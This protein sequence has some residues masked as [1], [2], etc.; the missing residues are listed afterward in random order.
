MA[1]TS[2]PVSQWIL[3]AGFF[4][5]AST[6]GLQWIGG[7][8]VSPRA[9]AELSAEVH[10]LE[11]APADERAAVAEHLTGMA[12][13]ANAETVAAAS[14]RVAALASYETADVAMRERLRAEVRSLAQEAETL[15]M[16]TLWWRTANWLVLALAAILCGWMT[17]RT[18]KPSPD[19]SQTFDP[20]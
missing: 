19:F 13:K 4:A 9:A 20:K 5:V 17:V 16:E 12:E 2:T 3:I 10:R 1:R 15:E 7:P 8:A 6:A 14:R 18:R 11:T